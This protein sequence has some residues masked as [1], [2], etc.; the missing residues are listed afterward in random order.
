[1]PEINCITVMMERI[2]LCKLRFFKKCLDFRK[3]KRRKMKEDPFLV[4]NYLI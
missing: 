4:S 2:V 1:M 3:L